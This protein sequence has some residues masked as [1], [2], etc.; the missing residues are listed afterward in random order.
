M[1]QQK[2]IST[3]VKEDAEEDRVDKEEDSEENIEH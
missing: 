1:A 2:E 3:P